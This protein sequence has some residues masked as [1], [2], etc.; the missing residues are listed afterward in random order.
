MPQRSTQSQHSE[1]GNMNA[2]TSNSEAEF[3]ALVPSTSTS[4]L[5]LQAL[6]T[7]LDAIRA[8]SPG[9]V[10]ELESIRDALAAPGGDSAPHT[11]SRR[12][13]D[14]VI[15]VG[16][17]STGPLWQRLTDFAHAHALLFPFDYLQWSR[18]RE[19]IRSLDA[20]DSAPLPG[21]SAAEGALLLTMLSRIE[22]FSDGTIARALERGLVLDIVDGILTE[23]RLTDRRRGML[24]GLAIGDT[25]G[26]PI[27]FSSPRSFRRVTELRGGGVFSLPL[28]AYTDDTSMALCLADSLL[29][30]G[31]YN[32]F[33]L[34][35][36][37]LAWMR[38]GVRSST[39][40]CFDV[41]LQT[42]RELGAFE[43]APTAVIPDDQPR[44]DSAGNGCIMRLAPLVIAADAAGASL[45]EVMRLA[46]ISARE[47][48]YSF[49]AEAATGL[50]AA[51]LVQALHAPDGT[52]DPAAS[53]AE[54]RRIVLEVPGRTPGSDKLLRE[55][56]A[57]GNATDIEQRITAYHRVFERI[58]D[59]DDRTAA[60]QTPSGYIVDSLACALWAFLT[61]D[62]FAE[63]ALAAVNLG[64]DADTIG[65]ILG[66][67]AGA[68]SG[69]STVPER[70][71]HQLQ[72][73]NEI[74]SLADQL[75]NMPCCPV[76]TTRFAEDMKA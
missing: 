74:I 8:L 64:G 26:M 60:D 39:G 19:L 50:F 47:T 61:H 55:G 52:G 2:R 21:F 65:A 38:D 23:A 13:S 63:Q 12:D 53:A 72:D 44:T 6:Q 70:W 40:R 57:I 33:D 49:E 41:G 51:M 29:A 4:L 59:A 71:R 14:G 5:Q 10:S 9:A 45:P 27:E 24:G 54:A 3:D 36:R 48:H 58:A 68:Y 28:G 7:A 20:A 32:S 15:H 25:L 30:S 22:R 69:W 43:A 37:W 62:T 16:F 76:I 1:K 67:L 31:G 42:K 75:G 56:L 35:S 73:A 17:A 34:M 46:A 66:Q 11:P 18:G